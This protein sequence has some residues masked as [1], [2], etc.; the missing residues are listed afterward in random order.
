[1]QLIYNGPKKERIM[2]FPIPVISKTAV[3]ATVTFK[4]G[5]VTDCPDQWAEQC[6]SIAPDY[7]KK[8]EPKKG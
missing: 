1:M 7:F 6:L 5:Q 2:E 3:E 4:R 8:V